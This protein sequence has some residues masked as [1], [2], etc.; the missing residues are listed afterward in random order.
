MK[1]PIFEN[2]HLDGSSFLLQGTQPV[3][4]LLLHG[5]TATTVEVRPLAEHLNS[6]GYS[7]F[8]PLLPGHG[9]RPEDMISIRWQDWYETARKG[10]EKLSH[11][12]NVFVAGESMGGLLSLLLAANHRSLKGV[13]LYA[14]AIKING[15]WRAKWLAPFVKIMP[16]NY[17]PD[18]DENQAETDT[19][20][21]QGY[22]VVALAA[23]A[24]LEKLQKEVLRQIH[25]VYQPVLI[26]QGK[27]DRTINPSG[28][29][30]LYE[31]LPSRNKS[32]VWLENSGHC[33]VLDRELDF[34]KSKT[35]EFIQNLLN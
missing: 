24:Q 25:H 34:V 1:R 21:W 15:I 5:F 32:L 27:K 18:E 17:L 4:V 2:P 19:L 16:K 3:G 8:C 33:V 6:Q 29:R 23:V 35:V 11:T 13:I 10:L 20:P 7:V 26:F 28:S 12:P 22:N 30:L 9:T 14:P 31:K